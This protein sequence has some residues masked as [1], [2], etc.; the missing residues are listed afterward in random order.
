[1]DGRPTAPRGFFSS[2]TPHAASVIG[3]VVAGTLVLSASGQGLSPLGI[4][5]LLGGYTAGAVAAHLAVSGLA[6]L[7]GPWWRQPPEQ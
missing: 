4:L 7:I 1:M 5:A 2:L 6:R 3:G